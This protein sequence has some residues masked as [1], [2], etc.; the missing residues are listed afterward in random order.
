MIGMSRRVF[1]APIPLDPTSVDGPLVYLNGPI[2][3]AENWQQQAI[4]ILGE[5]APDL[6]VA[7]PRATAF[8]GGSEAQLQWEQTFLQRADL[9]LFWLA[10]ERHHQCNRTYAAQV[11]FELG[12]WVAKAGSHRA[13]LV[14]GFERGF[15]GASYLQ[16]RITLA[17]PSIPVCR[18]LRQTCSAAA[19]LAQRQAPNALPKSLADLFRPDFSLQNNG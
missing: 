17:Y 8:K 9:V 1:V 12:E 4:T 19:E 13:Q 3:G 18:T 14:V 11:R 2:Q 15:A 5:L 7:S 6:H 10:R 16:R